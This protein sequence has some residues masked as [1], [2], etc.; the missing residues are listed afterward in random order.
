MKIITVIGARPQFI[1]AAVVSHAIK[2][3]NSDSLNDVIVHT[4]QHFDKNM[5]QI[6]FDQLQIPRPSYNLNISGGLHGKMTAEMLI[7]IEK[8]LITEKPNW[9]LVYGDTNSTLA[10]ALAAV[11]LHIPVI[12]IESG[13]RSFN[14]KMP[15]EINRMLVDRISDVHF[16]TSNVA[17]QHLKAEGIKNKVYNV[18]DVMY[19]ALLFH[20]S[21]ID[22]KS[23]KVSYDNLLGGKKSYILITCHRA[24]NTDNQDRLGNILKALESIAKEIAVIF[25]L[26]PRT[27]KLIQEYGFSHY[28]KNIIVTDP[29]SYK[30]MLWLQK[31]A[32]SIIT[33]SGGMQKEAY[34]LK[35]PCVTIR[36][37]TEWLETVDSGA[38]VIVGVSVEKIIKN[39]LNPAVSLSNFEHKIYGSGDAGIK[40]VDKIIELT[41]ASVIKVNKKNQVPT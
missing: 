22:D 16:C 33:D 40:I 3:L 32:K 20:R 31:N 30:E 34:F 36:E 25:P 11:K 24:E 12:H 23:D 7:G 8:I 41:P 15:E 39:A 26:H 35:V 21:K 17:V 5:S 6:F 18:G 27:K 9:V 29:L 14:M 37:E 13:L 38:N 10:G 2:K 28:L 4:G 1:K 19:D